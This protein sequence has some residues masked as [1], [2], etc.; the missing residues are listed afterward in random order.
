M[1]LIGIKVY[2]KIGHTLTFIDDQK[3]EVSLSTTSKDDIKKPLDM[4]LHKGNKELPLAEA[5]PYVQALVEHART[6][7]TLAAS[8]AGIIARVVLSYVALLL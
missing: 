3:K 8:H 7:P 4:K 5:R 1:Q 6:T 2:N